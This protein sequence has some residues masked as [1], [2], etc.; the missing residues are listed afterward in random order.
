VAI[1][2]AL[3]LGSTSTVLARSN[4]DGGAFDSGSFHAS[5]FGGYHEV[6]SMRAAIMKG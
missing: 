3:A 1:A 6:V 2:V 4:A 5:G